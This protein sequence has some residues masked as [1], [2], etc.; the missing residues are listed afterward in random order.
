MENFQKVECTCSGKFR[1]ILGWTS[2]QV[3]NAITHIQE[4]GIVGDEVELV[5]T[6]WRT[7][8]Q[9]RF[10]DASQSEHHIGGYL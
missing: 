3:F 5:V 2:D 4:T 6:I 7:G 10:G 1:V 9:G 8:V